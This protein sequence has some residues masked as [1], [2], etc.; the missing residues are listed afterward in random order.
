MATGRHR[1]RKRRKK[2]DGHVQC[3]QI[4]IFLRDLGAEFSENSCP[5]IWRLF[6]IF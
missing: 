4:G 3:D 6:S 1:H 2:I 5:N